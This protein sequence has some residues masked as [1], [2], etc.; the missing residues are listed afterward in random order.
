MPIH[1]GTSG[2]RAVFAEEFT[3]ANVR[4]LS[5]AIAAHVLEHP[6]FGFEAPDYRAQAGPQSP[7]PVPLVVVGYDTRFLSEA[8]AREAAEVFAAAGVRTLLASSDVPTPAL[9][10]A[11]MHHKAV[12][13]VVITASHNPAKYNGYKWTPYWGGPATPAVTD[14]IERRVSLLAHTAV[15]AMPG[16]KAEREGWVVSQDF[17]PAYA[18]RLLSLLDVPRLKAA[19]LRVGA[20]AL[21]G[22]VRQYLRPLFEQLGVQ[23]EG[24]HEERDVLFAG[25]STEPSPERLEELT[26]LVKK[27]GLHLGVACDGDGD[28]FGIMD[29]G[30][31]WIPANDVLALAVDHLVR[32]RGL[33]GKV[34]RSLMTSHFVDA[35]AKSHGLEVRETPVGFKFIGEFLRTGQ[36]LFGGEESG[37]LSIQGHVPEKDGLLACLL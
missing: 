6:E 21:G 15:A 18:K 3:F 27:K 2:W 32:N 19:R 11:V 28:R 24:L 7:I 4:K 17:K 23:A 14:D 30:G 20:D 13:G 9:A 36:F 5:A 16:D 22:A 8:F 25:E 26:A 31:V 37:G 33:R 34:A 1:F 12:G 35:V 29:A 10:Y